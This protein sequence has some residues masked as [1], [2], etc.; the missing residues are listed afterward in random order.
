MG[1]FNVSDRTTT[2]WTVGWRKSRSSFLLLAR[3][4]NLSSISLCLGRL[5]EGNE[6][7]ATPKQKQLTGPFELSTVQRMIRK[8]FIFNQFIAIQTY[9]YILDTKS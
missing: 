9:K 7:A 8:Y 2:H 1:D 4:I 5:R 3:G 6:N